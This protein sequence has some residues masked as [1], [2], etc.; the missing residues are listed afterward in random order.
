MRNK[1]KYILLN[2]HFFIR[3]QYIEYELFHNDFKLDST[4]FNNKPLEELLKLDEFKNR[5]IE[6]KEQS[7]ENRTI[8]E[9]GENK[10]INVK[11]I[12]GVVFEKGEKCFIEGNLFKDNLQ[13]YLK[14]NIISNISYNSIL[15]ILRKY[16]DEENKEKPI[17][18]GKEQNGIVEIKIYNDNTLIEINDSNKDTCLTFT[19]I[20]FIF[21][22]DL[23]KMCPV[24]ISMNILDGKYNYNHYGNIDNV[25]VCEK[26]GL[27]LKDLFN[28][29]TF[30][31]IIEYD[32]QKH[33]VKNEFFDKRE[34]KFILEKVI[35]SHYNINFIKAFKTIKSIKF[36]YKN[37]DK[38]DVVYD[39]NKDNIDDFFKKEFKY[40]HLGEYIIETDLSY[41]IDNYI[42]IHLDHKK[43]RAYTG[44]YTNKKITVKQFKE[45]LKNSNIVSNNDQ[46]KIL[47][48]EYKFI[49]SKST[50]LK[51]DEYIGYTNDKEKYYYTCEVVI[52]DFGE[53]KNRTIFNDLKLCEC[54]QFGEN[55]TYKKCCSYDKK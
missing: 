26:N 16:K 7:T 55:K 52:S 50:E 29:I 24:K 44:F 20:H 54:L 11:K 51:D 45:F 41:K 34:R 37:I 31:N 15:E 19:R 6:V 33:S 1:L 39:E 22:Q 5:Y 8:I 3:S 47:K 35:N 2:S 53:F 21:T 38:T 48:N 28:N 27:N 32:E 4:S 23:Y 14:K 30:G 49:G 17:E 46:L 36:K 13:D 43:D 42:N 18:F 9:N 40:Y 25:F 12:K 10:T